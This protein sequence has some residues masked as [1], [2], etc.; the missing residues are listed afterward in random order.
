M[1]AELEIHMKSDH[2]LL[3]LLVYLS[4]EDDVDTMLCHKVHI[5]VHIYAL[6]ILNQCQHYDKPSQ[7]KVTTTYIIGTFDFICMYLI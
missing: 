7:K 6:H 5:P 4:T 1:L 3:H 2:L